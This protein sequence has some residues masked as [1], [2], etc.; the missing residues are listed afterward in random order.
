MQAVLPADASCEDI[1]VQIYKL[2]CR[3]FVEIATARWMLACLSYRGLWRLQSL[4][5]VARTTPRMIVMMK[6]ATLG[7]LLMGSGAI[8]SLI[9]L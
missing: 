9:Y 7:F 6:T 8:R 2:L 3:V 5:V 1:E 4:V